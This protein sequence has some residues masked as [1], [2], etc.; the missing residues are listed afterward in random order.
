M[1]RFTIRVEGD[2]EGGAYHI[3]E[4]DGG[5]LD[6]YLREGLITVAGEC[7]RNTMY[8]WLGEDAYAVELYDGELRGR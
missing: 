5:D 1:I 7:L 6:H 2:V 8:S 4:I 3:E